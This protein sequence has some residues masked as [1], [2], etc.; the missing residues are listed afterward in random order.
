MNRVVEYVQ[1]SEQGGGAVVLI[2]LGDCLRIQPL[3]LKPCLV[4][5]NAWVCDFSSTDSSTAGS[6]GFA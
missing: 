3:Y 5:P 2:V 1:R 6:G 4:C